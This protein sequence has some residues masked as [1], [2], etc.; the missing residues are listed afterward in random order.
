MK[1]L[2]LYAGIGGNRKL[3]TDVEVT[4]VENNENI[5][6]I[7]ADLF[8]DDNIVVGDAHHYLLKY[9]KEYD[10]IWSSP[11]CT[12]HSSM[13]QNLAV[14]YRGTPP[15]YPDMRLYQEIIL[16]KYNFDGLWVVENV[17][18]YYDPFIEPTATL[19]RHLFWTNFELS[20][21]EF[22]PSQ[23]RSAQISDLQE[24]LGFDLSPYKLPDKR[25]ILRNCV[26]PP[27]GLH[28]FNCAVKA[29]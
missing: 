22:E 12:S 2:N 24:Y 15:M 4:A 19:H 18:P 21:A 9:F 14:R 20:A 16:L 26:Y 8:P 1:V 10:F 29:S 23:L 13:R 27:L 6:R 5:A 25:R 11:P 3:W 7:Y 28:V 17:N